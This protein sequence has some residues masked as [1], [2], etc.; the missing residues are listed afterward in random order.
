MLRHLYFVLI[1]SCFIP[2]VFSCIADMV[3]SSFWFEN[4][5]GN[6]LYVIADLNT[7]DGEITSG[8]FCYWSP[9]GT[10]KQPFD[11]DYKDPWEKAVKVSMLLYIVDA[12]KVYIRGND[13]IQQE[14]IDSIPEEAILAR[15]TVTHQDIIADKTIVY[16]PE[17]ETA[18]LACLS[19]QDRTTITRYGYLYDSAGHC[20]ERAEVSGRRG[21]ST[22]S[23]QLAPVATEK[24]VK[25][26]E[27]NANRIG[28]MRRRLEVLRNR[29]NDNR[30]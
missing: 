2:I 14:D 15:I 12:E 1:A 9:S 22:D 7:A 11:R 23:L 8:S 19:A 25:N 13:Y 24:T 17:D 27:D 21:S 20:V 16:P 10:G 3:V 4:K 26:K 6:D 18:L 30:Y 5:S 29:N 28:E